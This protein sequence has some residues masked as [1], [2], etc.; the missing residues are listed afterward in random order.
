M[1]HLG[2][3]VDTDPSQVRSVNER[4]PFPDTIE[5]AYHTWLPKSEL[6]RIL[7]RIPTRLLTPTTT[8][9]EETG[10]FR[11]EYFELYGFDT[12]DNMKAVFYVQDSAVS[13][14]QTSKQRMKSIDILFETKVDLEDEDAVWETVRETEDHIR[15]IM[16]QTSKEGVSYS[17]KIK[18]ATDTD[19]IDT[20]KFGAKNRKFEGDYLSVYVKNG[21]VEVCHR[22]SDFNSLDAKMAE[23]PTVPLIGQAMPELIP[24]EFTLRNVFGKAYRFALQLDKILPKRYRVPGTEIIDDQG[25]IDF[26]LESL[27]SDIL[28]EGPNG[29]MMVYYVHNAKEFIDRMN[30]PGKR[31]GEF[32]DAIKPHL[33]ALKKEKRKQSRNRRKDPFAFYGF[34]GQEVPKR[35]QKEW[36][37]AREQA[38]ER[39]GGEFR[40]PPK[41]ASPYVAESSR[42]NHV[43]RNASHI[44]TYR[45]PQDVT[46]EG[47]T[48]VVVLHYRDGKDSLPMMFI[49]DENTQRRCCIGARQL[50]QEFRVFYFVPEGKGNYV[51]GEHISM[52]HSTMRSNQIKKLKLEGEVQSAMEHHPDKIISTWLYGSCPVISAESTDATQQGTILEEYIQPGVLR[53]V[54]ERVLERKR[55]FVGSMFGMFGGADPESY[56]SKFSLESLPDREATLQELMKIGERT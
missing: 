24:N 11:P 14:H 22:V 54:R 53:D 39:L 19:I 27:Q 12:S 31:R 3:V 1:I 50:D 34:P 16:P 17:V 18:K 43:E 38:W 51:T 9:F 40:Y 47:N 52:S 10:G 2:T 45:F 33:Q 20:K 6:E 48:K 28:N 7:D 49:F 46:G 35:K 44:W 56:A 5:I 13:R 41:P 29:L 25:F 15:K 32:F 4:N 8:G 42:W 23:E 36:I 30:V 26:E 21:N 55:K 37:P